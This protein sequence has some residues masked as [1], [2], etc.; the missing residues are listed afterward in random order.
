MHASVYWRSRETRNEGV[1]RLRG[2]LRVLRVLLDGP[3]KKESLLVVNFSPNPTDCPWVHVP[4]VL[5]ADLSPKRGHDLPAC[6]TPVYKPEVIPYPKF[7]LLGT[8]SLGK[9]QDSRENKR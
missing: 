1:S 4:S 5:G 9:H 6:W 8:F 2:H 3:K 7:V